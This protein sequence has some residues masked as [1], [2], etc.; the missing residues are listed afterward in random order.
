MINN[1]DKNQDKISPSMHLSSWLSPSKIVNI[2]GLNKED[3]EWKEITDLGWWFS[4]FSTYLKINYDIENSNIVDPV[5][6]GIDA[7]KY[8]DNI[9]C[10]LRWLK[11]RK[12]EIKVDITKNSI[13]Q[14]LEECLTSNENDIKIKTKDEI[15]IDMKHELQNIEDIISDMWN[16][17][18]MYEFNLNTSSATNIEWIHKLSQDIV[19]MSYVLRHFRSIDDK[20]AIIE[21][22]IDIMKDDWYACIVWHKNY[23]KIFEKCWF[24]TKY[25]SNA[26]WIKL[27]KE[28]LSILKN[29]LKE[30]K[31]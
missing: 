12:E 21:N 25:D 20:I 15:T 17:V 22:I 14:K 8:Y 6:K 10:A 19:F 4:N 26:Y 28:G 9:D 24:D 27:N 18:S 30:Y 7:V 31:I 16:D 13:N 3:L 2:F 11:R 29:K 1:L 5:L 23:W